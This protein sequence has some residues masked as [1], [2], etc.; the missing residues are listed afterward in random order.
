M[1]D[2]GFDL[3]G[4]VGHLLPAVGAA[5]AAVEEDELVDDERDGGDD[6]QASHDAGE[7]SLDDHFPSDVARF[8][9]TF[10][11]TGDVDDF[12]H[13]F[14]DNSTVPVAVNVFNNITVGHLFLRERDDEVSF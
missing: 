14:V 12:E 4:P 13:R 2:D 1:P 11:P 3:L 7:V 5:V 10:G 8:S 6:G 9:K